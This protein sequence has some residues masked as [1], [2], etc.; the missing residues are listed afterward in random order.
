MSHLLKTFFNPGRK[1]LSA[2]K[3]F[4]YLSGGFPHWGAYL[5]CTKRLRG[6]KIFGEEPFGSKKRVG[7]YAPLESVGSGV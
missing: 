3:F 6:G 2:V 5:G 1:G 4:P 7:R